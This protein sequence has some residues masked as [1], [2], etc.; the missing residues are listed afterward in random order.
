MAPALAP[1]ALFGLLIGSFLNVVA[2]RLPR[3]ESLVKPRSKCPGCATQL[4]AYD[5][6][7]VFS[8]LVLRGRCRGCGEKI[9]ARYPVVEAITA[10]LY[11][12]VVAVKH[13]DVEQMALGLVL[14]SFL[15][16]IAVIDL[17][18]KRIPNALTAPAA[19]L[20]IALGALL[21]PSD[22]PEQLAAGAAALIFFLLPTLLSKKGMG[23]GD[24][25]LVGVLGLYL[26]RAVAPAI[27]IAL[28]LGVVVGAAVV[29]RK[30]ATAGR[31]TK[32][33]FGPF[34]AVGALIAFFV[35][36]DLVGSY[37]DTF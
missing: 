8:W 26:G 10:A 25:K 11:V 33:P 14:V 28:I 27:F 37:T 21:A 16:P 34:L 3:G 7:P 5:N 29:A 17:D 24:V 32:I 22:L 23:M 35:G 36:D 9:S 13:D 12:L 18:V 4:K 20:A 30:G 15:V 6:I 2:W 1:A 19:V 31:K